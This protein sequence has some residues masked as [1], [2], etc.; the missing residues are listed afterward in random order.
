MFIVL[1]IF[2]YCN[3]YTGSCLLRTAFII[4]LSVHDFVKDIFL[5]EGSWP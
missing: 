2:K 4:P 5:A 1:Y 3:S